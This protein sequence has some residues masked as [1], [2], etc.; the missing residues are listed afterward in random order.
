[1][2]IEKLARMSQQE[3]TAIRGEVKDGFAKVGERFGK[4]EEDIGILRRDVESGF[5]SVG[6]VLKLMRE[7]LKEIKT[8]VITTHEDYAELRARVERLEKKVGVP[9]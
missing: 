3:F 8:N 9:R 1:M 6:E 4:M 2:T 5:N 7:D